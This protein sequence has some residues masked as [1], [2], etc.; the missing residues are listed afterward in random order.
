MSTEHEL[1]T[2][3]KVFDAVAKGL[4]KFE[5][6][7]DDRG[8]QVGDTLVLRKTLHTGEEMKRGSPLEYV[9]PKL[10]VTVT[11]ILRGPIYGLEQ[12]WVCMSIQPADLSSAHVVDAEPVACQV[13]KG[14][15][16]GNMVL[17]ARSPR[18]GRCTGTR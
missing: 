14:C 12:G 13:P 2:D 11:H 16:L 10:Y 3:P 4:K 15:T 8:Y 7:F 1:K 17:T 9:S 6:R 5:I 18:N